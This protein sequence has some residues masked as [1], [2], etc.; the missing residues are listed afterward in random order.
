[1]FPREKS[2]K[3]HK[4]TEITANSNVEVFTHIALQF[5]EQADRITI[6]WDTL[7]LVRAVDVINRN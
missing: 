3:L 7:C 1:M 5:S 2:L 4:W 6:W